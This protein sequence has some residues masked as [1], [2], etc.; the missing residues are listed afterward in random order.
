MKTENEIKTTLKWNPYVEKPQDHKRYLCMSHL[1]GCLCYVERICLYDKER[2][3]WLY[4]HKEIDVHCWMDIEPLSQII[5]DFT[6]QI[7]K[8]NTGH[9]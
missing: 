9:E 6:D 1:D 7:I 2:D 3:R 5:P 4:E 8:H